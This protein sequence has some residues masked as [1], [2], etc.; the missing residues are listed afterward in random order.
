MRLKVNNLAIKKRR[1]HAIIRSTVLFVNETTCKKEKQK[2]TYH[3][4]RCTRQVGLRAAPKSA[5]ICTAPSHH[6]RRIVDSST[7]YHLAC[8]S[9]SESQCTNLTRTS[10]QPLITF[11]PSVFYPLSWRAHHPVLTTQPDCSAGLDCCDTSDGTSTP[12]ILAYRALLN[13]A[14]MYPNSTE[15]ATRQNEPRLNYELFIL[16]VFYQS[17][18]RFFFLILR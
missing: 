6:R 13:G 2:V 15:H 7:G 18:S 9:G 10:W 5:P 16:F 11:L 14:R 4:S 1:I 12:T 8:F 3:G 17:L